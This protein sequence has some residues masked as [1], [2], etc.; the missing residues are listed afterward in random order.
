MARDERLKNIAPFEVPLR[1]VHTQE[2]DDPAPPLP[3]TDLTERAVSA[4]WQSRCGARDSEWS[5]GR[6]GDVTA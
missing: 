4:E 5:R 3:G 1:D 2:D 6:R